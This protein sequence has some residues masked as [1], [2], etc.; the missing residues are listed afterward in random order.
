MMSLDVNS[1]LSSPTQIAI[2]TFEGCLKTEILEFIQSQHPAHIVTAT[3]F[4]ESS[5]QVLIHALN[6]WAIRIN[7]C[8]LGRSWHSRSLQPKTLKAFVAI[9]RDARNNQ[10]QALLLVKP[11]ETADPHDFI[12]RAASFFALESPLTFPPLGNMEV[13]MIDDE[14]TILNQQTPLSAQD[15]VEKFIFKLR[16]V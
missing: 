4:G 5:K 9:V 8:Y 14:N 15:L 12:T 6:D 16:D 11:P 13:E 2:Q 10:F 3:L 1:L 7:R